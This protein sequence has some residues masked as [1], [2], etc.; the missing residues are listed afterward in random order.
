[1]AVIASDIRRDAALLLDPV[2]V[3]QE[4]IRHAVLAQ[5]LVRAESHRRDLLVETPTPGLVVERISPDQIWSFLA[6]GSRVALV[7]S[8]PWQ[9]RVMLTEE[10][11]AR[12]QARVGDSIEFRVAAYASLRFDGTISRM[13]PAGSR[14]VVPL[15]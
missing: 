10:Q 13:A 8:G 3:Q 5:S 6:Q 11:V 4:T 2:Q 7:V 14:T 15:P 1:M 9:V 12:I